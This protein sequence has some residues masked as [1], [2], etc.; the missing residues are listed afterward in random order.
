[1]TAA[2]IVLSA[3]ALVTFLVRGA[4]GA[5]S[6]IVFNAAFLMVF[7]LGMTAEL[8][9]RDGLYWL[10][11]ANAV[12]A[13]VML[14]TLRRTL[15]LEPITVRYLVGTVP[16]TILFSILLTR[17]EGGWLAIVLA[18]VIILAGT[19][20]ILRRKLA[21]APIATLERWAPVFGVGAGV[22]AGLY[23]MGGPIG[24][25]LFNRAEGDPTD[26]RMRLTIVT[27]IISFVRFGSIASQGVFDTERLLVATGTLPAVGIGLALGMWAHRFIKPAPFKLALGLLVTL[28][29]LLT[30]VQQAL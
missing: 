15:V 28:S 21:P 4:V 27:S 13:V 8:E 14:A 17:V 1:M 10:A 11:L 5:G 7:A 25:L 6:S 2:I 19:N 3:L 26:F 9:L 20:M 22:L 30:L 12:S 16:T 18:I 23:G 29:G 24:L